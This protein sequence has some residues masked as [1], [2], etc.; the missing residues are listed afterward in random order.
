[1]NTGSATPENSVPVSDKSSEIERGGGTRE[2]FFD[3]KFDK[4]DFFGEGGAK[5]DLKDT[6]EHA[7]ADRTADSSVSSSKPAVNK[8][9]TKAIEAMS[10]GPGPDGETNHPKKPR[11]HPDGEVAASSAKKDE[12]KSADDGENEAGKSGDFWGRSK[13]KRTPK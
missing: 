10:S 13:K 9:D 12:T 3:V 7:P 1:M 4:I 5:S 11:E 8:P 6:S 2:E